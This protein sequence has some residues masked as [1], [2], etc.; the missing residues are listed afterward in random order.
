MSDSTRKSILVWDAP[1]RV[2]HWLMVLTFAGA[3]ATADSEHW[4]VAHVTFGYTM[5]G[6]VT[7]R[8]LWGLIGTRHARFSSFVRGPRAVGAY[9]ASLAR[10]RPEHHAGHNPAG[11]VVILLLLALTCVTVLSG[12][13][14]YHYVNGEWI[15]ELHEGAAN[16]ML[17]LVA[18]HVAGVLVSSWLHRENL[19]RAM[20][21][22]RKSGTPHEAIRSVWRPL[23]VLILLAVPTFWWLHWHS[24]TNDATRPGPSASAKHHEG[25]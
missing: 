23:A 6:L 14:A 21:S 12:W 22:G 4:R 10:G 7:F 20:V 16:T 15:E 25:D 19:L 13:A 17:V 9:L 1:V 11:A 18:I 24:V 5:V 8:V 2:F 3:F